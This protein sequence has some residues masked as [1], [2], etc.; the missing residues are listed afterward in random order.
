M[1]SP[2]DPLTIAA[3]GSKA[4]LQVWDVAANASA[5]KVFGA[6]LSAAGRT[7]REKAGGGI[8]SVQDDG[9]GSEWEDADD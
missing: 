5:R 6:R 3:A 4:K 2:D 8:V 1:F 9:E 7:L